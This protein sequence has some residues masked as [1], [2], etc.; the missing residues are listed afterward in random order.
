MEEALRKAREDATPNDA[1][2]QLELLTPPSPKPEPA[3][4]P[5]AWKLGLIL[6]VVVLLFALMGLFG[7][8]PDAPTTGTTTVKQEASPA[9]QVTAKAPKPH[10]AETPLCRGRMTRDGCQP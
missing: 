2:L 10:P 1:D 7:T 3:N 5:P 9:Q 4:S 6:A 8:H